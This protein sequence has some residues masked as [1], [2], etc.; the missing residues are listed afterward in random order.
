M[1]LYRQVVLGHVFAFTLCWFMNDDFHKYPRSKVATDWVLM[2][3]RPGIGVK[4]WSLLGVVGIFVM[5]SG[6]AFAPS[7]SVSQQISEIGRTVTF[8]NV[9]DPVVWGLIF[10][11]IGFMII[12]AAVT[13]CTANS[14][15][16]SFRL[17]REFGLDDCRTN[18]FHPANITS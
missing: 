18:R 10:G 16:A 15:S 12:G 14:P 2:L 3:L 9:L 1:Y 17:A 5:V 11:T 13:S 7:V 6:I 8:I 4:R